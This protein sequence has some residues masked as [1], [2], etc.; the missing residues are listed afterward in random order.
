MDYNISKGSKWGGIMAEKRV[1][2]PCESDSDLP[3]AE[4]YAAKRKQIAESVREIEQQ[5]DLEIAK[6]Q[7][8]FAVFES[9]HRMEYERHE[10]EFQA[11]LS[12]I[13]AEYQ[14]L[15]QLLQEDQ[16]A[17]EKKMADELGSENDK[18]LGIVR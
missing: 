4:L 15:F 3:A 11:A 7:A 2:K 8:D 18:Y 13:D 16:Q 1:V 9:E 6:I 14:S 5:Y 17:N 10:N 12:Y